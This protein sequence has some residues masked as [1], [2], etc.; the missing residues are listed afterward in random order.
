MFKITITSWNVRGACKEASRLNIN[1]VI[2]ESKPAILCPQETKSLHWTGK[3]I[4]SL[5]MGS[6]IDLIEVPSLGLSGGLLMVLKSDLIT[7]QFFKKERHW[8][9][10]TGKCNNTGNIFGC[11]NV[12]APQKPKDKM[13]V[14]EELS[15]L[16]L[17]SQ[18]VPVVLIDDFNSVLLESEREHC[19]HS[20]VDTEL[21]SNFMTSNHLLDIQL[22]NSAYTWFGPGNKKS[23]VDRV[24]VNRAWGDSGQWISMAL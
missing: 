17:E 15:T 9:W 16:L 8:I 13:S 14:W 19:E 23:K 10:L 1:A 24:P 5:G 11:V 3:K 4:E 7:L 12:Y 6:L 18:N 20:K 21:L 22:S 2:Q